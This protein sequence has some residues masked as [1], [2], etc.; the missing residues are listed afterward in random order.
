ML[1]VYGLKC[2]KRL[3]VYIL[4]FRVYKQLEKSYKNL[5]KEL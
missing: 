1:R 5:A 2:Y 4:G 3:R